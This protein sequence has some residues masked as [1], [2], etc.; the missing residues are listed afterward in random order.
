MGKVSSDLEGLELCLVCGE[1]RVSRRLCLL[2][3]L[4]RYMSEVSGGGDL[5]GENSGG[6]YMG[7]TFDVSENGDPGRVETDGGGVVDL[8]RGL[9][10]FEVVGEAPGDEG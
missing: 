2:S 8:A 9:A 5:F 3:A 4:A 6:G 1:Q 7:S 10:W